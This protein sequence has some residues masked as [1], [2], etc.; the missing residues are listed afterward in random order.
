MISNIQEKLNKRIYVDDI[1]EMIRQYDINY[2]SDEILHFT[3]NQPLIVEYNSLR[4]MNHIELT[5]KHCVYQKNQKYL[6]D[7]VLREKDTGKVRLI[8][9]LLNRQK[10]YKDDINS[11]FL[12]Y[13]IN[14][15]LMNELPCA[16][17]VLCMKISYKLCVNFKELLLELKET[18]NLISNEYS[19]SGL[20]AAKKNIL[21]II[22][23]SIK[24]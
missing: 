3:Q 5:E 14:S 20:L 7:L 10:F 23:K 1:V 21:K 24:E 13:T 9:A 8:L 4:V 11:E 12:D 15:I 2:I 16:I 6:I 19:S 17:R 22:D 18:I